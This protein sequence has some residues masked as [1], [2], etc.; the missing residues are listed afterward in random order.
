M[1]P[2][3]NNLTPL[4]PFNV[5]CVHNYTEQGVCNPMKK[6]VEYCLLCS[7]Y[8]EHGQQ[9]VTTHRNQSYQ[10]YVNVS[11]PLS[12]ILFYFTAIQ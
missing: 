6:A 11:Y 5:L 1:L 4:C 2:I 10:H 12:V 3:R 8:I 7:N 9:R